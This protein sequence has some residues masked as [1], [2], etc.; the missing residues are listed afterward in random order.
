MEG[1]NDESDKGFEKKHVT[2][3]G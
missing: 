3:S 1:P 2:S